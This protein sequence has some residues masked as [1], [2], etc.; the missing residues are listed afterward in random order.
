MGLRFASS[1]TEQTSE[2][3][4]LEATYTQARLTLVIYPLGRNKISGRQRS[5]SVGG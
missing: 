1:Y 3:P 4:T 2:D 5:A